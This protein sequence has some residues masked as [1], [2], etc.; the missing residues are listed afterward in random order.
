VQLTR[1][2]REANKLRNI[3]KRTKNEA[4]TAAWRDKAN[5]YTRE[6]AQAKENKWKEYVN[7]ADDKSILKIK[8]YI[9]NTRMSTPSRSSGYLLL[10][11]FID[12]HL[13]PY[14]LY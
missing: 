12:S 6:I 5:E 10:F 8:D 3:Y 1:R 11:C 14:Y 4:H 9:T 2:R 13:E 7:N